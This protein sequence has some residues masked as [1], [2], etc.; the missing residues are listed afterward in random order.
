MQCVQI[1]DGVAGGLA[2]FLWGFVADTSTDGGEALLSV[3]IAGLGA[4][5]RVNPRF[6][7]AAPSPTSAAYM[8][9]FDVTSAVSD[10]LANVLKHK[11]AG[12]PFT[13]PFKFLGST[14]LQAFMLQCGLLNGHAPD[15]P[16]NPRCNQRRVQKR[17]PSRDVDADAPPTTAARRQRRGACSEAKDAK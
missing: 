16:Q 9:S 7:N 5:L 15:C 6:V 17:C 2:G 4:P 8:A 13:E 12:A 14:T 10:R 11:A 1:E 3:S